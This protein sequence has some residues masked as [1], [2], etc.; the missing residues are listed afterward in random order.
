MRYIVIVALALLASCSPFGFNTEGYEILNEPLEV[1]WPKSAALK[2]IPAGSI[3]EW[4]SPH[5]T[6]CDG[7]GD[8][9]DIADV[10]LYYLGPNASLVISSNHAA[11]KYNGKILEAQ[12]YGKYL[13]DKDFIVLSEYDYEE[14]M[15]SITVW[16]TQSITMN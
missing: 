2:Y 15:Q 13:S 11:I 8:C 4:K 6:L 1:A 3:D 14:V 9:E 7:G 5:E 10:L 16:G 12:Q